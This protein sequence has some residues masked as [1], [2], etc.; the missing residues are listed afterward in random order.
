[1]KRRD[2]ITLTGGEGTTANRG[3]TR[4]HHD[5]GARA[6]GL[7]EGKERAKAPRPSSDPR[8]NGTRHTGRWTDDTALNFMRCHEL[9]KSAN[10]ADLSPAGVSGLDPL[11]AS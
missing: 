6:R 11:A 7:A 9:A 4:D 1:M 5:P 2:F 3:L 8:R 10:F